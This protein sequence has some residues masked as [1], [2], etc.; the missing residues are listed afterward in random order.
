MKIKMLTSI[1]GVEFVLSPGAVTERFSAKESKR[2]IKADFAELT[3]EPVT[4]VPAQES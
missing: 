2:L 3:D 1:S 4:D